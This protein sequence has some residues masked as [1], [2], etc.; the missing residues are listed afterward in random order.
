M[1]VGG[2]GYNP[3]YVP[4]RAQ[5]RAASAAPAERRPAAAP[6]AR[7]GAVASQSQGGV[8]VAEMAYQSPLRTAGSRLAL[9]ASGRAS[10]R[11]L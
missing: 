8:A 2:T 9:G 1:I 7:G 5:L 11:S 4:P 10:I 6:E 3:N